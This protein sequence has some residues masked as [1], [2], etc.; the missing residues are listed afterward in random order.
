V[1]V[2]V[3]Y[4]IFIDYD[5]EENI[6]FSDVLNEAIAAADIE[7]LFELLELLL[8]LELELV[9]ILDEEIVDMLEVEELD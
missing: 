1:I 9:D 2:I 3:I 4:I 5:I 7:L 8:E 6:C